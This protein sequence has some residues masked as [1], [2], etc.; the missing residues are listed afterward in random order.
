MGGVACRFAAAIKN[1][2]NSCFDSVTHQPLV[3]DP[4]FLRG[5]SGMPARDEQDA[6]VPSTLVYKIRTL[7]RNAWK[8]GESASHALP[9]PLTT[10]QVRRQLYDEKVV[11][12]DCQQNFLDRKMHCPADLYCH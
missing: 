4:F 12:Y 11:R 10:L 1:T 5:L 7:C 8:H 3:H 2:G 6:D 9:S